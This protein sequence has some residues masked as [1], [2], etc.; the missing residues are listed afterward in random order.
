MVKFENRPYIPLAGDTH[1]VFANI[2]GLMIV[3][4]LYIVSP[5]C[6]CN[7]PVIAVE[8]ACAMPAVVESHGLSLLRRSSFGCESWTT[9]ASCVAEKKTLLLHRWAH[10]YK[11]LPLDWQ[12]AD[13]LN[14]T[15]RSI[16]FLD[17]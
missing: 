6:L 9:V 3:Y 10:F 7:L 17:V 8:A 15:S 13:K 11:D 1:L 16:A 4:D 5:E 2:I 12:A 14:G